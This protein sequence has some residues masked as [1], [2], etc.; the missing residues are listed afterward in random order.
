MIRILQVHDELLA[1]GEGSGSEL[2]AVNGNLQA[3]YGQAR[4]WCATSCYSYLG[5][6]STGCRAGNDAQTG[7]PT[8][9]T[10]VLSIEL[11]V[12][13]DALRRAGLVTCKMVRM[14]M[15]GA[16]QR[17]APELTG[18]GGGDKVVFLVLVL[19]GGRR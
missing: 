13:V 2:Q 4:R 1:R 14:S 18:G 6:L 15:S 8:R 5:A 12:L 11:R 16:G 19:R 7:L 3:A 9:E 10:L 17:H